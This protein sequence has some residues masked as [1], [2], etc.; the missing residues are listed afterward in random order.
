VL[1]ATDHHTRRIIGLIYENANSIDISGPLQ[2]FDTANRLL[3]ENQSIKKAAYLV[4]TVAEHITPLPLTGGLQAIAHYNF[5]TMPTPDTLIIP[6][7]QGAPLV[8]QNNETI[9]W[10]KQTAKNTRRL[11]STC[12]GAFILAKAGLLDNRKAT[13]HWQYANALRNNYPKVHVNDN[14]IFIKDDGVYS[15]AGVTSGIDLAL[16]LVEED[17]GQALALSVAKQVVV[18]FRRSGGQSQY[19]PLL[20]M[21]APQESRI[22]TSQQW[23]LEHLGEALSLEKIAAQAAV[24]PRH[25]ARLFKRDTGNTVGEF[26]TCARLDAARTLLTSSPLSIAQISEKVGLGHS[27]NMRRLFTQ[28]FKTNPS[29]YRQHF[30]A[31]D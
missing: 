15:S 26:I 13:T 19:S 5:S 20:H 1:I 4:E 9:T 18:V 25:F 17:W 22:Y 2:V 30:S 21:Q 11:A 14:A 3:I 27:E 8:V 31:Q 12:T 29:Q 7:G 10:L 16:A 28:Y 6:G 24:S 23:I